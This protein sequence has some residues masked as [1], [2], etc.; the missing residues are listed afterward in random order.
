MPTVFSAKLDGSQ[1][2]RYHH[3]SLVAFYL[4]QA[5]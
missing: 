2:V 1:S 5:R 4:R 3:V